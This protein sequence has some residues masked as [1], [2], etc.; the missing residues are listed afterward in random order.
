[1]GGP[2]V[3]IFRVLPA[4]LLIAVDL[5]QHLDELFPGVGNLSDQLLVE[6]QDPG[7]VHIC[8]PLIVG[9]DV[10]VQFDPGPLQLG[11]HLRIDGSPDGLGNGGPG[12]DPDGGDLDDR[13]RQDQQPAPACQ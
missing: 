8:R 3:G 9:L 10:V 6:P 11:Q 1:M 2:A 7:P 5:R 12:V 4:K 13:Q